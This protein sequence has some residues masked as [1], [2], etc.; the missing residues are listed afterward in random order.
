MRSPA[1]KAVR[2]VRPKARIFV[3]EGIA[4]STHKKWWIV[5]D[6]K[7]WLGSSPLD[8]DDAWLMAAYALKVNLVTDWEQAAIEIFENAPSQDLRS[9]VENY[10]RILTIG[11]QKKYGKN[12]SRLAMRMKVHRNTI[13]RHL[14][15][16]RELCPRE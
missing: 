4:V 2:M 11:L 6:D 13:T 3:R 15:K 14:Q 7:E 12:K 10:I 5:R 9:A 8:E 1:E 16:R